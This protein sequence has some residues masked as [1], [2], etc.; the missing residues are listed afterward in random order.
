M[1]RIKY[2]TDVVMYSKDIEREDGDQFR[3]FSVDMNPGEEEGV[4]IRICSWDE[5]KSHIL[6]DKLVNRK[7]RVT[8]ETIE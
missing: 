2:T 1:E 8:I 3:N 4:Y 6:F 5:S 7:V